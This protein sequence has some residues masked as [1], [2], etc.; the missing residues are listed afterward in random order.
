MS[1]PTPLKR[2]LDTVARF[3]WLPVV[4]LCLAS[5]VVSPAWAR[6]FQTGL[7][8]YIARNYA[9]AFRVWQPLADRGDAWAQYG[10]GVLY[11]KGQGVEQDHAKALEWYHK[12]AQQDH[13]DAQEKLAMMY[14]QGDG[15]EKDEDKGYEWFGKSM[16]SRKTAR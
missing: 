7:D 6:N 1:W 12:A 2:F 10:L 3:L 13:P 5:A 8:F 4:L 16:R 14:L 15:V 11:H 9:V